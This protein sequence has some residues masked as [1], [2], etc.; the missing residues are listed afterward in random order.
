MY[1]S[2]LHR[3]GKFISKIIARRLSPRLTS[4]FRAPNG[5]TGHEEEKREGHTET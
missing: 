3:V 1:H 5:S 4:N 2:N